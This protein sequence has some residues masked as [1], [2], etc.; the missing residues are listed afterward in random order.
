MRW[1]WAAKATVFAFATLALVAPAAHASF[2]FK[3]GK[4]GFSVS[5]VAEDGKPSDKAGKHP[6]EWGMHL[7]LQ[8]IGRLPRRRPA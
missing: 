4:E 7:R 5:V 1:R 2:G 8:R 6:D 3:P